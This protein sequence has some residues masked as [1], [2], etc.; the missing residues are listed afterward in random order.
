MTFG[1]KTTCTVLMHKGISMPQI[2][3]FAGG[4]EVNGT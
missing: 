3:A 2:E 4:S 1:Y